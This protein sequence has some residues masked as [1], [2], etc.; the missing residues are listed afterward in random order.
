MA[1]ERAGSRGEWVEGVDEPF[2]GSQV[3]KHRYS[4]FTFNLIA[5]RVGTSLEDS[6]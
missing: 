1:E 2:S 4:C 6:L 5:W 3:Q